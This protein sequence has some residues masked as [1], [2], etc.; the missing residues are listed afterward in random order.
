MK[1]PR[2][3]SLAAI[4]LMLGPSVFAQ[5]ATPGD[6]AR[7]AQDFMVLA[8]RGAEIGVQIAEGKDGG[9][10]VE[11]VR[12][13]SPAEK[14][15]LK[16]SDVIVEFD[17]ERV[18]SG[19]QFSRLVQET[20]PGRTVKA[21]ILRDG[22]KK[23]VQITPRE[24]RGVLSGRGTV[25]GDVFREQFG[26]LDMLR[27]QLPRGP[28]NFSFDMPGALSSR[29]LGVTIDELTDQLAQYF[30]AKDGVL[31]T[32]VTDGS[33]ASRAGL[34]AGDVITSLDGQ[35]VR[36]RDDLVRALRDS[37]DDD[38]TIGIVREK[39]ESSVKAKIEQPRRSLRGARPV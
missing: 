13:D 18:R 32:S 10:L 16:R 36:S 12:P 2:I 20:P 4:A 9:V 11:E 28:F 24:G 19:R 15:G 17:G 23:D 7:R 27:E 29:R 6:R 38:V 39:K 34:K 35:S 3:A 25:D 30:G 22:Q 31:V 14:A 8:G 1:T 33:P 5:T 21:T 26:D 37:K